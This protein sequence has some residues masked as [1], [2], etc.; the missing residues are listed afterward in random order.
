[1]ETEVSMKLVF[2]GDDCASGT[3]APVLQPEI[4]EVLS[5]AEIICINFEAPI[6]SPGQRS[7]PKAGPTIGQPWTAIE[8]CKQWGVTHYALANNHIM[9]YGTDGLRSTLE[10]M[11][12]TSYFGA[13]L[14]F[15]RA[16]EPCI[17]DLGGKRIALLAFAEAQFGVLK[18]ESDEAQAGFAWVDHP[19]ARQS[20]RDARAN[21]DYV[22]VQVHAGLE[23]F[24]LPLPEWRLRYRELIDLGA[25]LVIGHH[26]HLIQGSEC[27]R[28][29]MIYYSLGNFYMDVM[30]RQ[31]DSGSR[32]VLIVTLGNGGLESEFI[33]L[34]VS[35]TEVELDSTEACLDDYQLLCE[36]LSDESGYYAEVQKVCKEFWEQVYSGYYESA[37]FGAGTRPSYKSTNRLLCRFLGRLLRGRVDSRSNELMLLHNIGIETHRWVVERALRK[38]SGDDS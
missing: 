4:K 15:D 24:G 6:I 32:G 3:V 27:Y 12:E 13:G 19:K 29:K 36:K 16:Y 11:D 8:I 35:L 23:M 34:R 20:I 9:D 26:P 21:Y 7:S 30:L 14:T 25:D 17:I 22:I 10:H 18:D 2:L 1:M 28:G 5:S 33:P 37:L 31:A 38:T